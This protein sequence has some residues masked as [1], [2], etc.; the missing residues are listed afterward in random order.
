MYGS[1]VFIT[2]NLAI[3]GANQI[4][5]NLVR[6]RFINASFIVLSPHQ[7]PLDRTFAE[8]GAAVLIGDVIGHLEWIRDIRL[9][10]CNTVMTAH[11]VSYLA[12]RSIPHVWVLH[13]WWTRD[14]IQA[15]LANRKLTHLTPSVIDA[16][17][18]ACQH[19]VCVCDSQRQVYDISA[20]SSVV[21]VGVPSPR[22]VFQ[23]SP[24]K[25]IKFLYM[26]IVCPRKNQL[27]AIE[28]FQRFSG[29]RTDVCFD[30]VGARYN[31]D[32]E[33]EYADK[34]VAAAASDPRIRI[35][36]VTN[37]PW[38]YYESADVLL[39]CS[40][41]EVTPLVICEALLSGL[42]VVTTAV[43][44]IPE[45][46]ENG[47]HGFVVP[48]GD[49]EAFV[50][51]MRR[52]ADDP[53]LRAKLGAQGREHALKQFSLDRMMRDYARL[54]RSVS[55]ITVLVDMDGVLVDWDAGFRAVWHERG[56]IDRRKSY[57]MQECVPVHLKAEATAISR[58]PGFF[59]S[60]PPTQDAVA[61][62]KHLAD[63]PGMNVLICTAPL[64]ANP[65]CVPDKLAW[66]ER[67]L[68]AEWLPRVVLTNDK[69][70]VRGD[71]LIDD[72]P[73]ISGSQHPT[74][75]QAVFH[76]PYNA[77]CTHLRYRIESW[78]DRVQWKS[79]LLRLLKDVGHRLEPA[80]LG[81]SAEDFDFGASSQE[82]FRDAY[83]DWRMGSPKGASWQSPERCEKFDFCEQ[84]GELDSLLLQQAVLDCD[85]FEEIFLFRQHYRDWR[86]GSPKGATSRHF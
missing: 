78:T 22:S 81:I 18:Q 1:V 8:S 40:L 44:G 74:W 57:I 9:V 2:Q 73:D 41:N 80:D 61:A 28:L 83:R 3:S 36:D 10:I 6:G 79:T 13:E 35:H 21:F 82:S 5:V 43:A 76:Q 53:V 75:I 4:L 29:D 85:D 51:S 24:D 46:L 26:G 50:D 19:V 77:T 58:E 32:Y 49:D 86:Q 54:I 59:A 38:S 72:K 66:V 12:N 23:R 27:K 42:P 20:A 16:A 25:H 45:M 64:W 11:H 84:R 48:P 39:L 69:T 52:L 60:L 7:G 34:V 68:G 63:L 62:V 47:K 70:T 30:I 37:D 65:T 55:P 56:E 14:M 33:V 17:L 31:R 67:H 15:E 71:V